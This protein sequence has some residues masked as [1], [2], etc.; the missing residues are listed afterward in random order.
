MCKLCVLVSRL[1]D[2]VHIVCLWFHAQANNRP[3]I[4]HGL[5]LQFPAMV[6]HNFQQWIEPLLLA[7]IPIFRPVTYNSAILRRFE[8]LRKGLFG[9]EKALKKKR[10]FY[11]E[12]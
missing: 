5:P 1:E 2:I 3:S 7:R 12:L 10:V 9:S 4:R 6:M 8:Y 11:L